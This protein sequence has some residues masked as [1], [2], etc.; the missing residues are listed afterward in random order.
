MYIY[1]YNLII[2]INGMV[3]FDRHSQLDNL[4][5][6]SLRHYHHR[7][8]YIQSL[9]EGVIPTSLKL[10]KKPAINYI[11]DGFEVQWNN[12]L[13][14]AEKRL[15]ELLLSKSEILIGK[16][17]REVNEIIISIYDGNLEE[18]RD[19]LYKKHSNYQQQLEE[20]RQTKCEK[21]KKSNSAE[22]VRVSAPASKI[23]SVT[24][25]ATYL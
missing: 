11:S 19:E 22:N 23:S 5:Q 16:T 3:I 13:Y 7:E 21:F 4:L 2:V 24:Q 25:T 15:V 20:R 8:N 17:Q 14:D 6:K 1:I 18:K 10:K 9:R 12:V